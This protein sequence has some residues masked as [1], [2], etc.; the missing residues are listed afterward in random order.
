[1][2]WFNYCSDG[3]VRSA[4]SA[5]VQHDMAPTGFKR[6]LGILFPVGPAARCRN[7][8]GDVIAVQR[9]LNKFPAD[10]GGPFPLLVAD[11]ICGPKTNKA[12]LKFQTKQFGVNKADGVVD[13]NQRTDNEL[14][15]PAET[16]FSLTA[17]M[18]S[19]LPAALAVI[20]TARAALLS[21][22]ASQTIVANG[23]VPLFTGSWDLVVKHFQI[24]KMPNWSKTLDDI[25][26]IFF[27]MQLAIGHIPQGLEIIA[28]E[29]A[30]HTRGAVAFVYGGGYW[31]PDRAG[32]Y[33]GLPNSTIYL[34]PR[35]EGKD[36][37][38]FA[39]VLIHELA[40]YVGPNILSGIGIDDYGY[41]HLNTK[42]LNKLTPWQR[43]HNAD[44]YAQFAFEATG[45]PFRQWEHDL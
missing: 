20:T 35:L 38:S 2:T 11:G 26:R 18:I 39:Y 12:I 16:Y 31:L 33:Q 27:N 44:S 32:T 36:L 45:R 3:C 34:C 41:H 25:D 15:R 13:P 42:S 30:E 37:E 8:P 23:G 6:T 22:R 28:D 40:H 4:P 9:A 10:H 5:A 7:L 24:D 19:R 14:A 17:T 43:V 1:M 21:A 29:P